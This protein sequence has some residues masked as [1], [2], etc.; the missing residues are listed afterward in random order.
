MFL[1]SRFYTLNWFSTSLYD[2]FYKRKMIKTL[3]GFASHLTSELTVSVR[4]VLF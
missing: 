4:R 1:D 3:N 2:S